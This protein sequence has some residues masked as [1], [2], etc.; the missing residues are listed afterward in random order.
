M[1]ARAP[2]IIA[3]WSIGSAKFCGEVTSM[4]DHVGVDLELLN[5]ESYNRIR[6]GGHPDV[7]AQH[8][9]DLKELVATMEAAIERARPAAEPKVDLTTSEAP[10]G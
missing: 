1:N 3:R 2:I 7:V 4:R 9:A 5:S 8:L 10:R 6:F